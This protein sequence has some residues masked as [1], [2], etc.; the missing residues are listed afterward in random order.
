M[1]VKKGGRKGEHMVED[2]ELELRQGM[3]PNFLAEEMGQGMK[4]KEQA[5]SEA[6][7]LSHCVSASISVQH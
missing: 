4:R 2:E 3:E 1:A 5:S 6:C 7:Q